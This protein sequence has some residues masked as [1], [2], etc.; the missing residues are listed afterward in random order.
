MNPA[1]GCRPKAES[2]LRS[3]RIL[4]EANAEQMPKAI[5]SKLEVLYVVNV[6]FVPVNVL[7]LS[8]RP[9][10]S[11]VTLRIERILCN[12]RILKKYQIFIM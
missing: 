10:R 3:E 11:V 5:S 4:C 8:L 9:K 1:V 12:R 2:T 7:G 6:Y